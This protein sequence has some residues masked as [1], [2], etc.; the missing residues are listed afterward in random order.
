MG[1]ADDLKIVAY[2]NFIA[3]LSLSNAQSAGQ[4]SM[5]AINLFTSATF[6]L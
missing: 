6:P 1:V 5:L 2:L 4:Y 3:K